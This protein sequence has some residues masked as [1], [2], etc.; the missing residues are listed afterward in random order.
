MGDSTAFLSEAITMIDLRQTIAPPAPTT[1]EET[2][3]SS[4]IPRLSLFV[5]KPITF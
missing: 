1:P 2:T 5:R 4:A 3:P